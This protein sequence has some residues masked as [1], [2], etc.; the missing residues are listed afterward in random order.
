MAM[1]AISPVNLLLLLYLL[2]TEFE[3]LYLIPITPMIPDTTTCSGQ[4]KTYVEC[5]ALG[6]GFVAHFF[7][8]LCRDRM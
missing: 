4:G 6:E 8:G 1:G 2:S 5:V 7:V 3:R